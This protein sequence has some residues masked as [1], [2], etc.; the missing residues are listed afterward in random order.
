MRA[1]MIRCAGAAVLA[2]AVALST[3]PSVGAS[4][5]AVNVDPSGVAIH[6]FDS[7]AYFVD[8]TPRLGSEDYTARWHGAVWRFASL[9]NRNAFAADPEH[10]APRYGGFCAWAVS[11][12]QRADVDPRSAWS[13]VDDRLYLNYSARIRKR[14]ERDARVAIEEADRR[15]PELLGTSAP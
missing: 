12:G 6:G 9:E 11:R 15:W 1:V 4:E 8:R 14:W 5:P 13:I 3:G 7:V 10:Y 2:V